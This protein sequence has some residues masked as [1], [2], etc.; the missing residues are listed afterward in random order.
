MV[1]KFRY[2][3]GIEKYPEFQRDYQSRYVKCIFGRENGSCSLSYEGYV[4]GTYSNKSSVNVLNCFINTL[5]ELPITVSL[6][7]ENEIIDEGEIHKLL[8]T[9]AEKINE[10][11]EESIPK[12]IG[13]SILEKRITAF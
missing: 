4:K 2:N 3:N 13:P 10:Q 8:F 9:A 5:K 7:L 12:M 6:R 1:R 11:R